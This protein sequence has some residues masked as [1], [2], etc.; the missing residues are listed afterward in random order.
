M[1]SASFQQ[2]DSIPPHLEDL[3]QRLVI[4]RRKDPGKMRNFTSSGK[5]KQY[6]TS[7]ISFQVLF[8]LPNSAMVCKCYSFFLRRYV[9]H[10]HPI[11]RGIPKKNI[12]ILI[13]ICCFMSGNRIKL[14]A[15]SHQHSEKRSY[16]VHLSL[17]QF[18]TKSDGRKFK[19]FRGRDNLRTHHQVSSLK[20]KRVISMEMAKCPLPAVCRV[21]IHCM[22]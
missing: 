15:V 14:W 10:K 17:L 19:K 3:Y 7:I 21:N 8:I 12:K 16:K 18:S 5:A 9:T 6:P 4:R 2:C 22:M 13:C 20:D 1:E 11:P